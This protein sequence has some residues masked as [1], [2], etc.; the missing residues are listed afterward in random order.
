LWGTSLLTKSTG[1][2]AAVS[3]LLI[4]VMLAHLRCEAVTMPA[5]SRPLETSAC[6][7]RSLYGNFLTMPEG[8]FA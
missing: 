2:K 7:E 8:F 3:R 1:D 6:P 5:L 4:L